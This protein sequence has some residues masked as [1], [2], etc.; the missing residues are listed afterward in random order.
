MNPIPWETPGQVVARE[1][2]R[3]ALAMPR[4]DHTAVM[5]AAQGYFCAFDPSAGKVRVPVPVHGA[6]SLTGHTFNALLCPALDAFDRGEVTHFAMIHS[7]VEP[8]GHWLDT[9]ADVMHETGADLVSAVIPIKDRECW[10]TSTCVKNADDP[11]GVATYILPHDRELLPETFGPEDVCGPGQVLCVNTG[12]FLAD[13]RHP[14]WSAFEGFNIV[15]RIGRDSHGNREA[16]M[17]PEDWELSRH[18][19]AHGAKVRATWRVR[20]RH[21]GSTYWEF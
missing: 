7:D 11:W 13:L 10:R 8:F 19:H 6:G 3:V 15:T 1:P 14:A 12:L 18:L 16:Q 20:G 17:R 21:H 5:G 4:Y 9:L 2:I